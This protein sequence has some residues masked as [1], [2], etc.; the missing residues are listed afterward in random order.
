MQP[1][2][3]IARTGPRPGKAT[4]ELCVIV[5]MALFV[6]AALGTSLTY[7]FASAIAPL[8]IIVPLLI[9]IG[10]QFR[11]TLKASN[12][13]IVALALSR[14]VKGENS[15]FNA[16][17]V[18]IGWM[19][20]LL[21]MIFLVGHYI[22]IA[23]FMFMLLRSV[24]KERFGLSLGVAVGVT[25]IIYVLFEYGFNIEMYRGLVFRMLASYGIL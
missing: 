14:I 1:D 18:F 3:H 19:A 17:A 22:G 10:V 5:V 4:L 24:S 8:C 11:R 6:L 9:L 21:A 25:A 20:V 12:P 23:A 2:P 16:I 7:D 13:Q 15:V